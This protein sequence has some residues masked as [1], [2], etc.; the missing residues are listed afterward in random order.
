LALIS[1]ANPIYMLGMDTPKNIVE[2]KEKNHHYSKSYTAENI[3]LE[4]YVEKYKHYKVFEK[5]KDRIINVCLDGVAPNIFKRIGIEDLKKDI[6][7]IKGKKRI[8]IEINQ[9]PVICHIHKLSD[10]SKWNEISRQIFDFTEGR[11]I[12]SHLNSS[13]RPDAD[14]YILDCIM[15]GFEQYR[16]F[17]KPKQNCKVISL[18]HSSGKCQPALC[19]DRVISLTESWKSFLKT[20]AKIEVIYPSIDMKYYNYDI[21][22]S[23]KNYGRI[24]RYT[25]GKLYPEFNNVVN[26]VKIKIPDSQCILVHDN[27]IK[28]KNT[29]IKYINDLQRDD[30]RYKAK[31]LSQMPIFA[32]MHGN[33]IELFSLALLEAMASGLAIIFWSLCQQPNMLEVLGNVG[34]ICNSIQEFEDKLIWLLE[35]PDVKKEYGLKAKERAKL[36]SLEKM[37]NR[38]NQLYKE[39]LND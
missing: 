28:N 39:V 11:H 19:S 12:F 25:P 5:Y 17:K 1:G 30:N 23:N 13:I 4:K 29:N 7:K 31:L 18:V 9:K 20:T 38:W 16:N 3:N 2:K 37:I 6:E 22:Y 15:N 24:T 8:K 21:D 33:F 10:R 34:I 35:N 26:R 32:D 27:E 14:I 36:F